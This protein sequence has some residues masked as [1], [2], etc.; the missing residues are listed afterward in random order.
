LETVAVRKL[1]VCVERKESF[2][3]EQVHCDTS[4]TLGIVIRRNGPK[5]TKTYRADNYV[6]ADDNRF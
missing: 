4:D 2:D 1:S 3:D 6:K 5:K